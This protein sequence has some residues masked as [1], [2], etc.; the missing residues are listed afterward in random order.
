MPECCGSLAFR[1]ALGEETISEEGPY[2][3]ALKL[4]RLKLGDGMG[5]RGKIWEKSCP[6]GR[7]D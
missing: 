7:G 6:M 3:L 1:W 5:R 2:L 4:L